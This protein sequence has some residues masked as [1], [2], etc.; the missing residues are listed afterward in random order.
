MKELL[1]VEWL[2][3]DYEADRNLASEKKKHEK[4]EMKITLISKPLKADSPKTDQ[5]VR[6]KPRLP[7]KRRKGT[8]GP[9][10]IG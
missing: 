9:S 1:T 7:D 10:W 4:K 2:D 8:R 6:S 5:S 3:T